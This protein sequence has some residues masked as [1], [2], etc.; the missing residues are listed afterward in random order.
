MHERMLTIDPAAAAALRAL[1]TE[2]L[3]QPSPTAIGVTVGENTVLGAGS[4]GVRD[5]PA[6]VV[7][8]GS[9]ARV[10]RQL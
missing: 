10:E 9:P 6:N 5:L 1:L 3:G 8:A 4:V 7:A 2:L